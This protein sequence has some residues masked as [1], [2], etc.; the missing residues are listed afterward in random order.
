MRGPILL[1][2]IGI[3]L[4]LCGCEAT[5]GGTD[6]VN[7]PDTSFKGTLSLDVPSRLKLVNYRRQLSIGEPLADSL[8]VYPKPP[9][10]YPF[11]DLPPGLDSPFE[12]KGWE[13]THDGFGVIGFEGQTALAV[14][15]WDQLES[16]SVDDI[17]QQV[18]DANKDF[19]PQV[20]R[21]D[22]ATYWMYLEGDYR[23]LV[24]VAP[25]SKTASH[26]VIALG[27]VTLMDYL[28]LKPSGSISTGN[29]LP[30]TRGESG[31]K[32]SPAKNSPGTNSPAMNDPALNQP[33]LNEPA[34]NEA[35]SNESGISKN[36]TDL[37]ANQPK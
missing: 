8:L 31:A 15:Q 18:R 20:T 17:V 12:S 13:M 30:S 7:E 16:S 23:L 35:A 27:E 14:R 33:S 11:T 26:L 19:E 37:G 9:K 1:L 22:K 5:S 36:Q 4:A 21:T 24:S 28:G 29:V 32:N 3:A 25:V 6:S 34:T 10:A 2:L